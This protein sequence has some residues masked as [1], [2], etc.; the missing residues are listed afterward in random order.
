MHDYDPKLPGELNLASVEGD[1]DESHRL[2]DLARGRA[3]TRERL[4]QRPRE[5]LNQLTAY[6]DGSAIYGSTEEEA[7]ALRSMTDGRMETTVF[8]KDE[9]LPLQPEGVHACII[10]GACFRGGA[11]DAYDGASTHSTAE[12]GRAYVLPLD[13]VPWDLRRG[14][15][16]AFP[17][18]ARLA[19]SLFSDNTAKTECLS[20]VR[21]TTRDPITYLSK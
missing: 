4:L 6:L 19:A 15:V 20:A 5:Q 1:I 9:M 11:A 13:E 17:S 3:E 10:D 2:H 21:Q 16:H 12:S 7:K 8:S 18:A 14:T